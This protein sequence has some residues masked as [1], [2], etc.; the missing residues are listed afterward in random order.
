M[1]VLYYLIYIDKKKHRNC[2]KSELEF[3]IIGKVLGRGSFGKVNLCIHKLSEKLVAIKS[4]NKKYLE[5]KSN[6]DRLQNEISVLK[7]IK[8]K[9]I[10]R[11]YETFSNDQYFLIVIELCGGGD[12]LN[13]MKKR[14]KFTEPMAK[15]ILNQVYVIYN[16][17]H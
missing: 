9:N 5:D 8:H 2:P 15:A 17:D 13:Y 6:N 14:R 1:T 7:T 10:V 3:Y 11:L 4:L 16:V 12:L